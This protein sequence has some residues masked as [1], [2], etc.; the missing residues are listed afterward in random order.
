MQNSLRQSTNVEK[1]SLGNAMIYYTAVYFAL[2][3]ALYQALHCYYVSKDSGYKGHLGLGWPWLHNGIVN[4]NEPNPWWRNYAYQSTITALVGSFFLSIPALDLAFS[5]EDLVSLQYGL[6]VL[7]LLGIGG[8]SQIIGPGAYKGFL[9]LF[10]VAQ[11]IMLPSISRGAMESWVLPTYIGAAAT[12][13]FAVG[14]GWMGVMIPKFTKREVR[15][16]VYTMGLYAIGTLLFT[17]AGW[18]LLAAVIGSQ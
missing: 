12:I 9:T 18:G 1:R 4:L 10:L 14:F 5:C 3:I 7:A 15:K 17:W 11:T 13:S 16:S 6:A 2:A 8:F